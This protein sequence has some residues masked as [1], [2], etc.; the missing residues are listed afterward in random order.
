VNEET[1][2]SN[3]P[4]IVTDELSSVSPLSSPPPPSSPPHRV[5]AHMGSS[6]L[7]FDSCEPPPSAWFTMPPSYE[8]AIKY[9]TPFNSKKVKATATVC[10]ECIKV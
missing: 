7:S 1:T 10:N 6:N 8:D 2:V 9:S 4:E 5:L 3:E